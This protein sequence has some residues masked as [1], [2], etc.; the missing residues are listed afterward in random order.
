MLNGKGTHMA[1]ELAFITGA[2]SGIGYQLA[3]Q[4]AQRGYDVAV[5]AHGDR[6]EEAAKDFEAAG[7]TVY[8]FKAD[9]T[10][11][12]EVEKVWQQI[13]ALGTPVSVACI[14]AGIGEAGLFA[15]ESSL[16]QELAIVDLNCGSTVQFGKYVA[17]QMAGQRQGNILFTA[18]IA[19]ETT[20]PKMAVY[21]ASKA[22]VLSLSK[23][24]R[25]ELKDFGV[26]VTALQPGPVDT[27]FFDVAH[28][29]D[30]KIG[31]DGKKANQPDAVAKTGLDAL[32]NGEEHVYASDWMTKLEGAVASITPDSI[33]AKMQEKYMEPANK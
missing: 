4:L 5:T 10:K 8:T 2:S 17:K 11:R 18:S 24:L 20:S 1:K 31:T 16:E 13:E 26:N 25:F 7:A 14:N 32:F 19:S 3:L 21:S 9:A 33:Q 29:E 6:L 28:M 15:T 30:T 23:S 27:S 22:F 12:D